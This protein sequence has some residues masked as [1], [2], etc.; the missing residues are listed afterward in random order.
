M[1]RTTK[2]QV[3]KAFEYFC[4]AFGFTDL[5]LDYQSIYGGYVITNTAGSSMPFGQG[6]LKAAAMY[7]ALWLATR[8]QQHKE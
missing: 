6:R 2:H 5:A 8:A 1:E 4:N 7:D 3:E